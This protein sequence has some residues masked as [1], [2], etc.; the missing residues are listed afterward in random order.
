MYFGHKQVETGPSCSHELATFTTYHMLLSK[1]ENA[2]AFL[3]HLA[4][5]YY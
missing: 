4:K 1:S 2:S 3:I 5:L